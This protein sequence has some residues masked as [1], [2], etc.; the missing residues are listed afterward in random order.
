M[1]THARTTMSEILASDDP[2]LDT[3]AEHIFDLRYVPE[4]AS[5][6]TA[7]ED[8]AKRRPCEDFEAF[9]PIFALAIR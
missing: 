7:P 6:K 1:T 4:T 8:I 3:E 2:L 5:S 9:A